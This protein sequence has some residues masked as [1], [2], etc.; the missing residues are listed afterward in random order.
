MENL[1]KKAL[2]YLKLVKTIAPEIFE[3]KT[4]KF[5]IDILKFI[6]DGGHYKACAIFRG[7]GKSTLLNKIYVFCQVFFTQEPFTM[8]VSSDKDKA[9]TFL[10]DIKEMI[11]T[12][13]SMG[14][15]ICKGEIWSQDRVEVIIDKGKK[16][17]NG[18]KLEKTSFIVAMGAG[19]D[20]RG[21]TYAYSRPTLIIADDL[22]SKVGQYAIANLKNRQKLKEWFFAD[23]LPALHPSKGRIIIIGTIIDIDS[24][25]NNIVEN[26][27]YS[28]KWD[29][30]IIPIMKD[31]KS[32]WESRFPPQKIEKIKNDFDAIGLS[33]EFYQEYMCKAIA[34]DKQTFKREYLKYFSNLQY[35]NTPISFTANDSLKS[36]LITLFKA[37]SINVENKIIMLKDT[38][39]YTTMDLAS[40][41]GH[42]RTAIV[43]FAVDNKNNIYILDI[44]CGHWNPFEKS[45]KVIETY[46][47]FNPKRFGIEK[48]SA[49]NDFF[50]TIDVMQK[51]TGIKIPVEPLSH[52]SKAKNTRILNLHPYFI[53]GKIYLNK[54][55][56][57]TKELEAELLAFN[58]E[59]QSKLDDI[60]DA[61]AYM[62]E[63]INGRFF[64][65]NDYIEDD[66]YET[67]DTWY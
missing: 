20:P 33:N 39:I 29:T 41:D 65:N 35:D 46:L 59:S 25:L 19:Q 21:Y 38:S 45:V 5:H 9:S 63:F 42:D 50:Y 51:Q 31:G 60:I 36:Q 40:Y 26:K 56:P 57:A 2:I 12:A 15:A 28:E 66:D 27:D 62:T 67:N 32:V 8:I 7:A 64:D 18:K 43:T 17:K 1:E 3:N 24:I 23:L 22:E 48:A 11:N 47:K 44:N 30:K 53:S 61:L 52:H 14:Y 10:K 13:N 37:N 6:L 4:P 49:Q 58:P 55:L 54:S 34:P 16:D